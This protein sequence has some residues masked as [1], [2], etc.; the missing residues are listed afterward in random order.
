MTV[1]VWPA[2][3]GFALVDGFSDTFPQL[4]DR[5]DVD[6]GPA[7][8]RMT[9]TGAPFKIQISYLMTRAQMEWLRWFHGSPDGGAGGAV[10]FEWT[11]PVRAQ[12]VLARFLMGSEPAVVA[13]P[14]SWVVSVQLEV[15]LPL[16]EP[17]P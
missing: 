8:Q 10:W 12:V 6:S 15:L 11:Y 1:P 2:D 4:G 17:E 5:S 14:P 9:G 16:I 3:M 13:K 7:K